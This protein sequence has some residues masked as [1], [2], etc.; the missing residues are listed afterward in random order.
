MLDVS[1]CGRPLGR[2]QVFFENIVVALPICAIFVVLT[3]GADSIS[4]LLDS[5][6]R[7]SL[8]ATKVTPNCKARTAPKPSLAREGGPLAVDE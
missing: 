1:F 4:A 6:G 3:V 5:R 7:L 8:Q 2:P